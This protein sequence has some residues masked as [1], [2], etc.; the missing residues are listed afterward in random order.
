MVVQQ[1]EDKWYLLSPS[2][3]LAYRTSV[4]E[5]TVVTPFS[6]MFGR[7][8]HLPED[9]MHGISPEAYASP[10]RYSQTLVGRMRSAYQLVQEKAKRKQNQ[11]KEV[12]EKT[13]KGHPYQVDDI[14][15][16]YSSVVPKGCSR[17]L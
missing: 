12:Y 9:I 10:E 15:F 1:D 2:L 14:V 11:Q 3:L 17:S 8:P 4:H 16:R 5:P 6:L 7:D 13:I